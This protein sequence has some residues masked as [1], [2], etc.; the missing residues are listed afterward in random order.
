MENGPSQITQS[1]LAIKHLIAATK[2][3]CK[4]YICI[5]WSTDL[6]PRNPS[7]AKVRNHRY[8]CLKCPPGSFVILQ[9]E[10]ISHLCFELSKECIIIKVKA[11]HYVVYPD[12]L[13]GARQRRPTWCLANRKALSYRNLQRSASVLP[14]AR[15]PE[16][17]IWNS[18]R[19]YPEGEWLRGWVLEV[20]FDEGS[21]EAMLG[22]SPILIID[23]CYNVKTLFLTGV[24]I[25]CLSE[26]REIY[27]L[28]KFW[29]RLPSPG[30]TRGLNFT[31]SEL[32]Q[33]VSP[34]RLKP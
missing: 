32:V 15:D 5:C 2:T 23:G 29:H 21:F 1:T 20:K 17:F 4:L 10:Q 11:C 9:N 27:E 19:L 12:E 34:A 28:C 8:T 26:M 14:L 25:M 30:Q 22:K 24:C 16:G 6:S 18:F 7:F 13:A 3:S 31:T 33:K